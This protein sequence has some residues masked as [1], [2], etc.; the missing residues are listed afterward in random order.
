MKKKLLKKKGGH[1]K[2]NKPETV[3]F[4]PNRKI[5]PTPTTPQKESPSE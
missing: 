4:Y 2:G 5:T 1:P 3:T